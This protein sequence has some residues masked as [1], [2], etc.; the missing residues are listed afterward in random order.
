[1]KIENKQYLE[2]IEEKNNEMTKL[3]KMVGLV[4]QTLNSRKVSKIN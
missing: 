1:L 3:K 2:K 4:T